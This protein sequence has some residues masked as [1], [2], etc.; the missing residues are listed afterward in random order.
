[1]TAI[2]IFGR[3]HSH[4]FLE[5]TAE[6]GDIAVADHLSDLVHLVPTV[7]QEPHCHMDAVLGQVA[8]D[9]IAGFLLE[10]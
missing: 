8:D 5:G 4:Q 7:L 6:I 1:M 10:K 3:R 2:L 9:R